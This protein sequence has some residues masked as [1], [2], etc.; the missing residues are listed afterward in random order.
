MLTEERMGELQNGDAEPS[1]PEE[2]HYL[3]WLQEERE[4]ERHEHEMQE[5]ERIAMEEHFAKHPHG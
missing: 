2:H 4:R 3:D 5:L 1:T